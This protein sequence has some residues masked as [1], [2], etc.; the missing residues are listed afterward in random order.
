MSGKSNRIRRKDLQE[1]LSEAEGTIER[2]NQNLMSLEEAGQRFSVVAEQIKEL[3]ERVG[4]STKKIGRLIKAVEDESGS[5]AG[6][7]EG[8]ERVAD[9]ERLSHAAAKALGEIME[10]ARW[11][12]EMIQEIAE[13]TMEE[14]NVS[15]TTQAAM[16]RAREMASSGTP[17]RSR[18]KRE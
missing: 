7:R 16:E 11:T 2:L 9:G 14:E 3:A 12:G 18:S 13:A 15:Q 4:A 17:R 5:A 10:R 6:V 8:A 1:L